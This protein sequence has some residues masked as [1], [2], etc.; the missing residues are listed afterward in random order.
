M[1][2]LIFQH[3]LEKTR[4][5]SLPFHISK[6]LYQLDC[7]QNTFSI[8]HQNGFYLETR[9]QILWM[10]L[11]SMQTENMRQVGESKTHR[12]HCR[13]LVSIT[14]VV[15]VKP[16]RAWIEL[17][18]QSHSEMPPWEMSG[19]PGK[20]SGLL[21]WGSIRVILHLHISKNL[22]TAGCYMGERSWNGSNNHPE[23]LY[24]SQPRPKTHRKNLMWRLGWWEMQKE[25]WRRGRSRQETPAK[26]WGHWQH[27]L[28][29]ERGK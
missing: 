19:S 18:A 13:A 25:Q 11:N 16:V 20:S 17:G 28:C 6:S 14:G 10:K 23:H 4:V 9:E 21:T 7:S 3:F 22:N 2:L 24:T 1:R 8:P 27:H 26:Q 5:P 29:M 15:S 12:D